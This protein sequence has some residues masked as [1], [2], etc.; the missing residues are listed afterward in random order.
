MVV[1]NDLIRVF[2]P[3]D[4]SRQYAPGVLVG[5]KNGERDIFIVT[6]LH[7]VEVCLNCAY[8]RISLIVQVAKCSECSCCWNSVEKQSS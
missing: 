4:I 3:S 6:V 8:V 1:N 2:W 7:K 5:F